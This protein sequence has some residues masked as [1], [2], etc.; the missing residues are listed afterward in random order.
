MQ[1]ELDLDIMRQ[2]NDTTCGP[3]CLHAVYRYYN[4]PVPLQEIIAEIPQA[5]GGGTYAVQLGCHALKRGYQVTIFPYNLLFF[6]PTWASA[7]PIEIIA[8]LR[9]QLAFKEHIPGFESVTRAFIEYLELGGGIKF[10]VITAALIRRYLKRSIPVLTDLS[11]T[12]LY[13]CA[14]EYDR[15]G[16]LIYDDVRGE[17]TTHFVV[18]AGYNKEDRN[19]QVADPL[20]HPVVTSQHYSVSIYRLVCAILLG[21]LTHDGNMLVIQKKNKIKPMLPLKNNGTAI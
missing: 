21:I 17:S 2:P 18:L 6:D 20:V 5:E 19:V 8:K 11:A 3:T 10:E 13:N 16:K 9:Q 7:T 14:R 15:K 12:Y 4:D 1:V